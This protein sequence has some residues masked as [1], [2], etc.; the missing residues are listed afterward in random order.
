[1]LHCDRLD[2]QL[3][4]TMSKIKLSDIICCKSAQPSLQQKAQLAQLGQVIPMAVLQSNADK[5]TLL[6]EDTLYATMIE[7]Y[8]PDQEVDC[9]VIKAPNETICNLL[10]AYH[11]LELG[12][13]NPDVHKLHIVELL[14]EMA[15][16]GEIRRSSIL[17]VV[18]DLF[19]QSKRYARMYITIASSGIPKLKEAVVIPSSGQSGKSTHIPV[20]RAAQIANLPPDEQLAEL[21][22]IQAI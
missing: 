3:N 19:G 11:S 6:S 20:Q 16:R 17:S 13:E 8:E 22:L 7:M 9:L 12:C 2:L 14:L 5:Y 21:N 18:A 15:T 4:Y 1:M 10:I